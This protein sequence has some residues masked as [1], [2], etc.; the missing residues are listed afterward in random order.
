MQKG[1]YIIY[2][3]KP[4]TLSQTKGQGEGAWSLTEAL[5]ANYSARMYRSTRS[6]ETI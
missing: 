2:N 6:V 1:G 4:L 5:R 3:R